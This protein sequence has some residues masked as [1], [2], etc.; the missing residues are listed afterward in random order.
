[1]L[2]SET[3]SIFLPNFFANRARNNMTSWGMS[4][5]RS[6]REGTSIGTTLRR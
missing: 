5:R 1:M 4:L 2:P 3:A 6:R